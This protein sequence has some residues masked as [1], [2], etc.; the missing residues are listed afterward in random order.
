VQEQYFVPFAAGWVFLGI[1]GTIA[2]ALLKDPFIKRLVQRT[3]VVCAGALFL[4]MVSLFDASARNLLFA[5]PA[6]LLVVL[7][8][9]F[10]VRV[11]DSCAA[12]IQPRYFVPPKFCSKCGAPPAI[13][14]CVAHVHEA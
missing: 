14:M 4:V 9:F 10:L 12:L 13:T 8:N 6:V 3:I 5:G 7:A 11:C 1:G 2:L